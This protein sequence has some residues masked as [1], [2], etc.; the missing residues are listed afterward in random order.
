M[1]GYLHLDRSWNGYL[2]LERSLNGYLHLERSLNGY[3]HLDRSLNGYLHVETYF[4]L[5]KN[6]ISKI[7][8]TPPPPSCIVIGGD[9]LACAFCM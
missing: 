8:C 4:K 5:Y 7:F 1:N 2:H 3:L 9:A 6:Y